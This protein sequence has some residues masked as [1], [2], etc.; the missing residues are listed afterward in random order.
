MSDY[1]ET[2]T[3]STDRPGPGGEVL[4][5]ARGSTGVAQLSTS[6][7]LAGG[8]AAATSALLGSYFG[9]F[10]TVGGAAVGS[11][12]TTIGT[13]VYQRSLE[14]ARARIARQ[15]PLPTAPASQKTL[16]AGANGTVAP[17][18]SM[19]VTGTGGREPS[20]AE[21]GTAGSGTAGSGTAGSGTAGSA[22]AEPFAVGR[23]IRVWMVGAVVFFGVGLGVVTAVEWATGSP[24]SGGAGATS[25]GQVLAP[26]P[27]APSPNP[28]SPAQPPV[29]DTSAPTP[30]PGPPAGTKHSSKSTKKHP[31]VTGGLP[32]SPVS[33]DPTSPV[34]VPVPVPPIDLPGG[35]TG[36]GLLG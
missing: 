35:G 19:P 1:T 31:T 5:T 13:S 34:P 20:L 2:R 12:V 6:K 24:L 33:V 7:V 11:V 3:L 32:P 4:S 14:R 36:H 29:P 18:G 28:P 27:A 25:L 22:V 10:G 26:S 23:W 17:T 15:I 8:M 30:E 16:T 9:A 21:P